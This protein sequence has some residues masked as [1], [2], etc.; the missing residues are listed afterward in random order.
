[1]HI[2]VCILTKCIL[3][4]AK[5]CK[6]KSIEYLFIEEKFL[7]KQSSLIT[8]SYILNSTLGQ[9]NNLQAFCL[10]ITKQIKNQLRLQLDFKL[11]DATSSNDSFLN[12]F[13]ELFH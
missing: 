5:L 12:C 6:N 9:K 2:H 11:L 10:I 4:C 8:I 7:K 3:I 13:G 1:M